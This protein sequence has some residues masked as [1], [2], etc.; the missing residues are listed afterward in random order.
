MVLLRSFLVCITF[1]AVSHTCL[2]HASTC[3]P[4][5]S[6]GGSIQ[7][8]IDAASSGD[9]ICIGVGTY[10]EKLTLKDGVTLK[11]EELARTVIDGGGSGTVITGA[12]SAEIYNITIKNGDIGIS[13]SGIT[14][15]TISN[16]I[17]VG[18]DYGISC[19]NSTSVLISNSVIDQNTVSGIY[20]ANSSVIT[21]QNSILFSNIVDIS[22]DETS[23][24]TAGYNLVYG[25]TTTYYPTDDTTSK[26][27]DPFFV[28]TSSNDYHLK[29]DSTAIDAG[30]GS[31][32]DGTASDIGAYGG[33]NTDTTPFPV[34]GLS[35]SATADNSLSLSWSPNNAYN[36]AGYSIY[37]DSDASGEPYNGSSTEGTSP[38]DAGNTTSLT[39][40]GLPA[41]ISVPS[42]PEG[43]MTSPGNG[44]FA[45]S[46]N[47]VSGASGYKLFYGTSSGSYSQTIDVGSAT[48]YTIQGLTNGTV[49]YI[50]VSSYSSTTYYLSVTPYD[51]S[52]HESAIL[53]ENEVS[54]PLA[55]AS[56][57]PK[58]VEVSEYPEESVPF[59]N[60]KD[61]G[62][63]FIATAAYG[64]NLEPDVATLRKFRDHFLLT[65]SIGRAFVDAYYQVSPPLADYI[66][67][68][69]LLRF[70]VRI[71][72]IPFIFA[73][74]FAL[75]TSLMQKFLFLALL[76][77][78]TAATIFG[79]K[80]SWRKKY[81]M[82]ILSFLLVPSIVT[83][84][85]SQGYLSLNGG[86]VVSEIDGW[87]KHYDRDGVWA[88]GVEAGLKLTDRLEIGI[89]FNYS[90]AEGTA[91]TPTGRA[92]I[93]KATYEQLPVNLSLSYRLLFSDNQVIVPSF[94]GGYTHFIY[95]EKIN[96]QKISGDLAGYHARGGLQILLDYFDPTTA[97]DFH[98]DWNISNTYLT[99][100]ALYSKVDDF[101]KEEIDLGGL[102]YFAGLRFEY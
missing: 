50:A 92:S 40:S 5:V 83:A 19:D 12:G 57:S 61:E 37:F 15:L 46:W 68:H 64:S 89:G 71:S 17:V 53:S 84:E 65:N 67:G 88:G 44:S 97:T 82:L 58:S 96:D 34:S 100:E 76:V 102:R 16:V 95:R 79:R 20:L 39:L 60:L 36:I 59:P 10:T 49:Y 93:D 72:L 99:F 66:R 24:Y 28:A 7:S 85:S 18:N 70:F 2:L 21:I 25:N 27:D 11:G 32:P 52:G 22:G 13:A 29:S 74:K 8:A 101:G 62:L 48:S 1:V 54:V 63:C 35:S 3:T 78:F 55:N 98:S 23:S 80:W 87:N 94:G 86:Y 38:V 91:T 45:V 43:V 14:G 6:T 30:T 41:S 75:A 47:A 90:K 9:T 51:T 77:I 26:Y 81:I 73:A 56:E 69:D 33:S 31:D 4:T 42:S